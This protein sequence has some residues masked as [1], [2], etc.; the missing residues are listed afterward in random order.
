MV[1]NLSVSIDDW[2]WKQIESRR[3]SMNRSEFVTQNLVK[4]LQVLPPVGEGEKGVSDAGES[5]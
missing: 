5:E 4:G 3:G 1:K 2:L